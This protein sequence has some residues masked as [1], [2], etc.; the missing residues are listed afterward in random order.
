MPTWSVL[1]LS[2]WQAL[3]LPGKMAT[4]YQLDRQAPADQHGARLALRARS[5][6][7]A[8]MVRTPVQI[9]G[10]D[11]GHLQF[12]WHVP[13]LIDG[14]DMA[15]RNADDSPVRLVLA[16]EG[17]RSQFSAKDSALSE[18][19]RLVTGEEMPYATLMYVWCNKRPIGSV[20][21]NARTDRIRKIVVESGPLGLKQWRHYLR[22]VRADYRAAFGQ[23]PGALVGIGIMTDSDNTHSQATAWY[24][25]I[26]LN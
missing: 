14:A 12:S 5:D 20:I 9:A 22:D 8:S 7:S 13:A 1:D 6:D 23:E 11:L 15:T 19:T 2:Q 24:G 18:L 25:K 10:K 16:F 3:P 21:H 4:H 26:S 17:D